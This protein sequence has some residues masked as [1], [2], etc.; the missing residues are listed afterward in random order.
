LV[1][2]I[3]DKARYWVEVTVENT[4]YEALVDAD[5]TFSVSS[6]SPYLVLLAFHDRH[7]SSREAPKIRE[8]EFTI[9]SHDKG[10]TTEGTKGTF[11]TSSFFEA[12]IL[13]PTRG[14][15]PDNE[16]ELCRYVEIGLMEPKSNIRK[17]V[18]DSIYN[19]GYDLAPRPSQD[20]ES[21]RMHCEEM[22]FFRW[23]EDEYFERDEYLAFEEVER[24]VE[25]SHAWYLQ[26]NE[27]ARG[28]SIFEGDF[29]ARHRVVWGC[30]ANPTWIGNGGSGK[31]EQFLDSLQKHDFICVWARAKVSCSFIASIS[32]H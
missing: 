12:S 25:G 9:V 24:G 3:L 21:H 4:R 26:G 17:V 13:R 29:M 8:I 31:G 16:D 1:L 7:Q 15:N 23:L 14:Y 6:A 10:W 32:I 5:F 27:V 18:N 19:F 22:K 2:D 28:K 30:K 20:Y 11:K